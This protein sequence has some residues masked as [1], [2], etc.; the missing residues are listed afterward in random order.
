M[1]ACCHAGHT[2]VLCATNNPL[3]TTISSPGTST[4]TACTSS[5]AITGG[6]LWAWS[7]IW[8]PL[9]LLPL[10]VWLPLLPLL[11]HSTCSR[12]GRCRTPCCRRRC[13][14]QPP[15]S[16]VP[17]ARTCAPLPGSNCTS[18]PCR[19]PCRLATPPPQAAQ[20]PDS[21]AAAV[22]KGARPAG[23]GSRRGGRQRCWGRHGRAA[24]CSG[25]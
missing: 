23:H 5:E 8:T 6:V 22:S 13:C 9:P 3:Q 18:A 4:L 17:C 11:L 25:R 14:V 10:P 24:R 16:S 21:A 20:S 15:S 7:E 2:R 19:P 12:S 1:S